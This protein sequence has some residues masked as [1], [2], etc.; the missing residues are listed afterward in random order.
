ML[1]LALESEKYAVVAAR[2]GVEGLLLAKAV[3][4]SLIVSDA[5]MPVMDGPTFVR[6]YR[7]GPGP[8]A[9]VIAL[10][11]GNLPPQLALAALADA[12]VALPFNLDQF[13]ELV[14]GC[15]RE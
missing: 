12:V 1:R 9:P 8:H 3:R 6:V 10:S 7:A 2:D 11:A 4:P 5:V 13:Y 15:L 14:A